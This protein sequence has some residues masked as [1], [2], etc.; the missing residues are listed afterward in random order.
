MLEVPTSAIKVEV[1]V[2]VVVR[3]QNVFILVCVE[4][5]SVCMDGSVLIRG[6]VGPV[7]KAAMSADDA[8]GIDEAL[9]L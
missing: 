8:E 7:C 1:E 9:L 5:H 2:L 4:V 6:I 3:R